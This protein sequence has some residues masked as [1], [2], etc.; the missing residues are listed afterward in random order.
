MGRGE[1]KRYTRQVQRIIFRGSPQ[2]TKKSAARKAAMGAK[3]ASPRAGRAAHGSFATEILKRAKGIVADY[4]I[5][6]TN[7]EDEWYGRGLELPHVF[8][9]GATPASCIQ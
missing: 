4:Q 7:E 8:G 5:I 1:L 3:A 2:P 9:D 6:L